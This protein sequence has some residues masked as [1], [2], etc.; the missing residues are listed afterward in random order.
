MNDFESLKVLKILA[1]GTSSVPTWT[2]ILP[3]LFL[4]CGIINNFILPIIE[5]GNF[6]IFMIFVLTFY[7][8]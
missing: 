4:K 2:T 8:L 3:G 5:S 6:R 1:W 7:T